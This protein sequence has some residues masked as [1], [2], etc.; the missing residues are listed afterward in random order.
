MSVK[1]DSYRRLPGILRKAVATALILF[2]SFLLVNLVVNLSKR[3]KEP[4]QNLSTPGLRVL[5][6]QEEFRAEEI[7]GSES[8][9]QVQAERFLVDENGKQHL[10]GKV[11]IIDGEVPEKLILMAEKVIIDPVVQNLQAEGGVELTS[12][13]WQIRGSSLQYGLRDK[14]LK[15]YE[16]N[17]N[18]ESLF[19]ESTTILYNLKIQ[20]AVFEGRVLVRSERSGIE[21]SLAT[22]RAVFEKKNRKFQ[23]GPLKFKAG[24]ISLESTQASLIVSEQNGQCEVAYLRG[25]SSLDWRATEPEAEVQALNLSSERFLLI[26]DGKFY[27]LSNFAFFECKGFGQSW[28]FK[29]SGRDLHLIFSSEME[30]QRFLA[31]NLEMQFFEGG[32]NFSLYGQQA[33][34]QLRGGLVALSGEASGIFEDYEVKASRLWVYP[35][36]RQVK[37]EDYRAELKPGFFSE[38]AVFFRPDRP[39]L[40][41]GS[42]LEVSGEVFRVCRKVRIWQG[43]DY[44]LAEKAILEKETA[45]LKLQGEVGIGWSYE[46]KDGSK[47]RLELSAGQVLFMA[48]VRRVD[49]E[50]AEIRLDQS[51]L[52]ARKVSIMVGLEKS[53]ELK[54]LEATGR[55][56]FS[57]NDYLA[58]GQRA[59][60][61]FE[62]AKIVLTG[63]PVLFTN[64]GDR[65]ETDKLTLFLTDDIIQVENQ[66][67]KRSLT[68]LVRGK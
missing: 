32:R 8:K 19:I 21:F 50:D 37:A 52:K 31:S 15:A 22:E 34:Y 43:E 6:Y 48:A 41:S 2:V 29:G 35:S 47:K 5:T 59:S 58:T 28:K 23:T 1:A 67:R 25:N 46:S 42:G 54:E 68:I 16:V 12:G 39:V 17:L 27:R 62:Q 38:R 4:A 66:E 18:W 55:L 57:W 10:E 13:P 49:A 53:E 14:A 65:L 51:R 11:V 9:I 63:R 60:Y 20:E 61:D 64:Q 45:N 3:K 24:A 56:S 26:R 44:L 40:M 33:D 36:K 30:A 7:K